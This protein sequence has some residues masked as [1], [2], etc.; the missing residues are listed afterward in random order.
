[1]EY[2]FVTLSRPFPEPPPG[3]DRRLKAVI[4]LSP[5]TEAPLR[6]ILSSAS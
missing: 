1:M 2:V 5:I 4:R 6:K 3:I